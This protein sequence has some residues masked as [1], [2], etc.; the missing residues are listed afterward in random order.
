[1]TDW[2]RVAAAVEQTR[3]TYDDLLEAR[4]DDKRKKSVV[5]KAE[6]AWHAALEERA[7]ALREQWTEADGYTD[8]FSFPSLARTLQRYYHDKQA[9]NT[10]KRGGKRRK[11][12]V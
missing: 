7:E 3:V 2:S 1:M 5:Q 4:A 9:A 10:A 6:D 8:S 11:G 12:G